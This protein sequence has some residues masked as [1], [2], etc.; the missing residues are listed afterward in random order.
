LA[1]PE[2]TLGKKTGMLFVAA[3]PSALIDIPGLFLFE[4]DRDEFFF[5]TRGADQCPGKFPCD[6]AFLFDRET[7]A[8]FQNDD[9]QGD[10]TLSEYAGL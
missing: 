1:L 6:P 7:F 10:T 3:E 2:K 5:E 9:G 4:E 8:A